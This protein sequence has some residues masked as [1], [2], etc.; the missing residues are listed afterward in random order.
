MNHLIIL[1]G[2]ASTRMKASSNANLTQSELAA[3][4]SGNKSLIVLKGET[5]PVLDH[6]IKN[7]VK[8][9][10][11]QI[12]IVTGEDQIP[13]LEYYEDATYNRDHLETTIVL[14]KQSIPIHRSKPWGTADALL[15]AMDQVEQLKCEPFAICNCDNLYSTKALNLLQQETTPNA[16][17]AYN[18]EGLDFDESRIAKFAAMHLDSKKKLLDIVEKPALDTLDSYR[19][20]AG[21]L[22][23]S[24]N[25]FK[26]NG[27]DIYEALLNCPENPERKE[28]ELPTTLLNMITSGV[29]VKGIPLKEHVPDLTSK[30]DIGVFKRYLKG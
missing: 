19:D 17:I 3:A 28:K 4:N 8:A 1:A 26:F 14:A 20:H 15:Q 6:L 12:V 27:P 21:E 29:L 9:N 24:M 10:F 7:A 18:R 25:L 2:G 30:E 16:L 13:F 23:V 11:T 5:R 22:R